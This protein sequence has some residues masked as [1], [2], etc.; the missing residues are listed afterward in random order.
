[1]TVGIDHSGHHDP[2]GGVYLE[3]SFRHLEFLADRFD[4]LAHDEHVRVRE[5]TAAI[6]DGDHGAVAED[7]RSA[8]LGYFGVVG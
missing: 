2:V 8:V 1:V 6:I 3:R 5:H 4:I 7:D